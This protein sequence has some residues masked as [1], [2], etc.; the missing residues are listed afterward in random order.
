MYV[1]PSPFRSVAP[2][3]GLG[4][5]YM[6]WVVAF[7]QASLEGDRRRLL[8]VQSLFHRL[9]NYASSISARVAHFLAST[10]EERVRTSS[11]TTAQAARCKVAKRCLLRETYVTWT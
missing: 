1:G 9:R 11:Q 2:V 7:G 5:T 3:S 6:E 8:I 10:V 4:P